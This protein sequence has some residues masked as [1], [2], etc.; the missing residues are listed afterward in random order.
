MAMKAAPILLVGSVPGQSVEEVFRA[1]A[2]G[3]HNE[4]LA[5][6]DGELDYRRSWVNF[7]A[8]VVYDGHPDIETIT[9][10]LPVG[11][12]PNDYR[13][14]G[15][16]WVPYGWAD[17]WHFR[18][19]PG[20]EKIRFEFLGYAAEARKSYAVFRQMKREGVIAKDMRFE[21]CL[22]LPD[23]A[24]RW[25][26]HDERSLRIMT[27]AIEEAMIREIKAIFTTI[28]AEEVLIQWDACYEPLVAE[29]GAHQGKVP[30]M[31]PLKEDEVERYARWLGRLAPHIPA[32]APM[33]LH[34]C[35][36]D[37]G[38][39]HLVEPKDLGI[40]VKMANAAVRSAGRHIDYFHMP[41]PRV[42]SDDAYFAP[43]KDLKIGDTKIFIGLVHGSDGIEGARK[44]IAAFRRAYPGPAGVATECGLGR[45]PIESL[46]SLLQLHREA[47]AALQ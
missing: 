5:L 31:C 7:L 25:Y 26:T 28:P 9:R 17:I 22:P 10:P 35:Y 34:I 18:V 6:P 16:D 20:V 19:K 46:P 40:C 3:T 43:L 2:K 30:M 27:D 32:L 21:I 38:G 45:Q 42:R 8:F 12:V 47:A 15:G 24:V 11:A 23:S 4:A 13:A 37:L 29:P 41:V 33:G 1:C 14:P 39:H 44:R 36:G